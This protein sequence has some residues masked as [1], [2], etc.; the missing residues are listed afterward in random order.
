MSADYLRAKLLYPDKWKDSDDIDEYIFDYDPILNSFGKIL[1]KVEDHDYHGDSRILYE[2]N[3]KY[4]FLVFGWGSCSGCD[5]LQACQ[6]FKDLDELI[7]DLEGKIKWF[8]TLEEV[9]KYVQ[10]QDREIEYYSH[11]DNWRIFQK[12]VS[13]LC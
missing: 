3:G 2:K 10:H 4:G 7:T 8:D 9:Q 5:A 6:T 1:V 11:E 12:R 13:E